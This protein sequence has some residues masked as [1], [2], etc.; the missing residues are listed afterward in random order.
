MNKL[1]WGGTGHDGDDGGN[2]EVRKIKQRMAGWDWCQTDVHSL[3]LKA[4][5]RETWKKMIRNALDTYG[6][7]AHGS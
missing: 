1:A 7:C 5:D 4:L 3:S 2:R 6:L